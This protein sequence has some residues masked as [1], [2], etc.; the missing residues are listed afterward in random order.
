M[1]LRRQK[2]VAEQ[3]LR[4]LSDIVRRRVQDPRLS[5]VTLTGVQISPDYQFADITFYRL[6]GEPDALQDAVTGLESAGGFI[7]REL[8]GRLDIRQVPALRFHLDTSINH[9]ARIEAL[10]AQIAQD[11]LAEQNADDTTSSASDI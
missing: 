2:Q 11:K 7:R 6:G 4:E 8:A 10:L 3:I 5:N 1:S 9:V